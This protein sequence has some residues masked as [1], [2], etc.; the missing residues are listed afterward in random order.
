MPTAYSLHRVGG[1]TLL[2]PSATVIAASPLATGEAASVSR[3]MTGG[4]PALEV[5]LVNA[6]GQAAH[7]PVDLTAGPAGANI[8][9]PEL[10]P[11]A[12]GG[13][14]LTWLSA[15]SHGPQAHYAVMDAHGAVLANGVT[16]G[17]A[18]GIEA[19]ALPTGGFDLATAGSDLFGLHAT[20][21]L[22]TLSASGA[23]LSGPKTVDTS[24][25]TSGTN[26][27]G[28]LEGVFTTSG[29]ELVWDNAS[30]VHTVLVDQAGTAHRADVSASAASGVSAT[31][32]DN[33][34]VA[35]AWAQAQGSGSQVMSEILDP[36]AVAHGS[37][38]A[39]AFAAAT[40]QLSP[41]LVDVQAQS[42][43]QGRYAISWRPD[44][45][46]DASAEVIGSD[47]SIGPATT[48]VGDLAGAGPGG[49]VYAL[50]HHGGQ[51]W[52]DQYQ[53]PPAASAHAAAAAAP[54]VPSWTS[55][56]EADLAAAL[57][58]HGGL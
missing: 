54:S 40:S 17:S 23:L 41:D 10:T 51:A 56:Y 12:S 9:D 39:R 26:G 45:S 21:S 20:L 43:G 25:N 30:G 22:E 34:H 37:A 29:V 7:A 4:Q 36:T 11:L 50:V 31:A 14:V 57:H 2:G 58:P 16:S 52:L 33:G 15:Y 28:D 19:V 8:V 35:L 24:I 13:A 3:I 38:L 44:A 6:S 46:H 1:E 49:A 42:V 18:T 48:V 5:R 53:D 47:G 27:Y 55:A 32:L